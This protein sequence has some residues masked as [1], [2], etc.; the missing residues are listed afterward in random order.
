MDAVLLRIILA[1][2]GLL[3]TI[4]TAYAIPYFKVSTTKEQRETIYFWVK[5]AV[6]AAEQMKDAGLIQVPKKDFVIEYLVSIG[7]NITPKDMDVL[8]EAAVTELKASGNELKKDV[9]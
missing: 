1:L 9:G 6:Y 5:M 7:I 3:G 4:I 2:I 8:I